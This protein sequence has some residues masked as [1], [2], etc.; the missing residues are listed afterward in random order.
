M[1]SISWLDEADPSGLYFITSERV[2]RAISH[3][4]MISTKVNPSPDMKVKLG[5]EAVKRKVVSSRVSR[6]TRS[7]GR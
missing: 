4:S 7:M 2:K 3:D 1:K 6:R 5:S